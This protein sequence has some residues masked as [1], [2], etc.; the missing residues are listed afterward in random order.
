MRVDAETKTAARVAGEALNLSE[1]GACLAFPGADF[2]VGDEMIVWLRFARPDQPEPVPAPARVVW[3]GGSE[4]RP[5][6]G[7]H[8]THQGPHRS[9][10][11]WLIYS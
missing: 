1:G 11:G 6:Y 5:L 7:V 4:R 10:I 9:W 2:S 8:W 3:A